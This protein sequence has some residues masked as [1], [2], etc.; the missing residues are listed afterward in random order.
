MFSEKGV[1]MQHSHSASP[2]HGRRALAVAGAAILAAGAVTTA[3]AQPPTAV[4]NPARLVDPFI[5]TGNG[6]QFDGGIHTYPG[7]VVPFGMLSWSPATTNRPPGGDYAYADD[8]IL[9]FA[10]T[11]LSGPGC[12]AAAAVPILPTTGAIDADPDHAHARFN[13]AHEHAAAGRYE[14][15]LDPGT[16]GA[17]DVRLAT[18]LRTGLGYF[19]F[20]AGRAANF[21]FKVSEGQTRTSGASVQVIGDRKLAGS[22]TAGR[23]CGTPSSTTLYFVA[24][25]DQPFASYGTWG[26]GQPDPGRRA[27]MGAHAGAWVTFAA[28]EAREIGLKVAISYVSE[29]N[30]WANLAAENPGW[31]FAKV[32]GAAQADWNALLSRIAVAGG[33]HDQQVEFYTALYHALLH[34]NVFSDASGEY[35]GFDHQVHTLPHAQQYQYANYSGWDIYR[36]QIPLLALLV[37]KR[38]SDMVASL[39]NDQVQGGWL[40][41]W[42]YANTYT[43]IM[44]GDAADPIIAGAYAFGA[45]DFD[46]HAALAAMLKGADY[47]PD[48]MTWAGAYVERPNLKPYLRLGY[49][50]DNASETLEYALADFGIAAFAKALGDDAVHAKFLARS[51]NWHKLFNPTAEFRGFQGYIEARNDDGAFP[52]GSPFQLVTDPKQQAYG[53]TSYG[54]VEG[55][56]SQYTW[57]VPQDLAGLI[58]AMGGDAK[59][60]ARLDDLFTELN[61]GPDSP[62]YWAGKAIGVATPWIYNY[63]GAPWQTQ[64]VVRRLLDTLYSATPGGEP[65]NDAMG[66]TSA[67]FIWACLGLYP[68]TPGEAVLALSTPRFPRA[69]LTLA[70]GHRVE[71]TASG[72]PAHAYIHALAIDGQP[73]TRTWLAVDALRGAPDTTTRIDYTLSSEPD[74]TWGAAKA[75]RP[76]SWAATGSR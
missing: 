41:K 52:E 74:H 56:T 16:P 2:A 68:E 8:S 48:P 33:T 65:G 10:L 26:P 7:A 55:S 3:A 30:A 31:D 51:G 28:G 53:Q 6:G 9:G 4:S 5:G 15:T 54:F 69:T 13:H 57:L 62:Y 72:A 19:R 29:A 23:F 67:W 24:E 38:A 46:T 36:T 35:M 34:P 47:T 71:L 75:D 27:L 20:P 1:P 12:A 32:A 61:A 59:A 43:G 63:T 40:P 66:A 11:H 21:L 39:L 22:E 18:T 50:P 70:N 60:T 25:F 58:T 73:W 42:G 49:V 44:N 76:P 14:V 17:I 45:R 64:A 37:P